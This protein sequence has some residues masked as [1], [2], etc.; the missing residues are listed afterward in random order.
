MPKKNG[1]YGDEAYDY[2]PGKSKSAD[3]MMDEYANDDLNPKTSEGGSFRP[4]DGYSS[5]NSHN[6]HN[7]KGSRKRGSGY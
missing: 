7:S 1:V 6:S 2:T 4:M 3:K 5:H